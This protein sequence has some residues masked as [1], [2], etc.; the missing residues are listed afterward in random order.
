MLSFNRK[1][2]ELNISIS[3]SVIAKIR[4]IIK[5]NIVYVLIVILWAT[6]VVTFLVFYNNGLGLAYNDAR[7]HLNIGRGVVERP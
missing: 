5:E 2:L 4:N 1:L 6:S 7:S 3:N